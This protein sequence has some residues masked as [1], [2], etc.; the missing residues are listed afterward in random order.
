MVRMADNKAASRTSG[1]E[2]A[3]DRGRPCG[4]EDWL[5]TEGVARYDAWRRVLMADQ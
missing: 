1:N 5:R 2:V 4:L 3:R